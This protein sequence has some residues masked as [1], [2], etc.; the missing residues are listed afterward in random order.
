MAKEV[1]LKLHCFIPEGRIEV[2]VNC[3][4]GCKRKVKKVLQSV[5]KTEIDPLQP[6]V[7]VV[8]NVDPKILIKK[9][10]RCGKQAEIWSSGNQNAG[11]QNK[12]TDTA[13]AKEKEKSKSGCEEAKCSDSSATANEKSKESSKGGDG[14]ENKDSKKEQGVQQL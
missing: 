7:T 4:D 12:E 1:D 14:G 10:Q 8:G 6:K 11:K 2:T 3:C 9:L 13:L 5:L